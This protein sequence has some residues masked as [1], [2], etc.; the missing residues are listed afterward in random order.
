MA[1]L[2]VYLAISHHHHHNVK[3]LMYFLSVV[4][5]WHKLAIIKSLQS[6]LLLHYVCGYFH[7][8]YHF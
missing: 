7:F 6:F 3:N 8:L 2:W 1:D 4:T 5:W